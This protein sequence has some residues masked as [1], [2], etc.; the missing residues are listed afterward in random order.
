M[1][2]IS[3]Y[4]PSNNALIGKV[5]VTSQIE[6]EDVVFASRDAFRHWKKTPLATRV[7]ILRSAYDLF[8]ERKEEIARTVS[9][10]MG[11][12]IKLARDEV[13]Y[14][15]NYY[16]WY[17]DQAERYL[18]PET[19]FE[20]DTELHTVYYEPKGVIA[21]ITP[22]NYPFML[23][24]W[25]CIQPLLAGNTV[26]WKVSKEVIL[27]GKLIASIMEQAK[28]PPWVWQEVYG[29]GAVWDYLTDLDIDGITFTWS[30]SV[31]NHLAKKAHEKGIPVVM[32]L[33]WSAPGI[34]CEDA[35]I[36]S[37]LETIYFMRFSNSGQMCDGL[38]RLIV[39]A[40]RYN[41][42]IE[43]LSEKLASKKIG[44]ALDETVD[45]G[46]IVSERQKTILDEQYRDAIDKGAKILWKNDQFPI[47]G[48]GSYTQ[49][50]ILWNIQ[51][52]MRVWKEEVFWPILPVV[53][54]HALDEA[55]EL[56][57]DTIYG[58]WAYVFTQDLSTFHTLAQSIESGMVQLNNVNYCIPS[59]PFGGYKASGIGREH[60]KW[61][62]YEFVN[63]KVLSTPKIL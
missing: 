17:L 28:L 63:I 25:A 32:E 9:L 7:D 19:T 30:T 46:P 54:F 44:D 21:A 36:D 27:T 37:V 20:S 48:S 51:K 61:G 1:N 3:S 47:D 13:Q 34:I 43:K 62:F 58:L 52:D 6:I 59:D 55:I 18:S 16:I 60:G 2:E 38:K 33:G 24:A 10:E 42:L 29:D 31:G 23:F 53:P 15:L 35:D 26:I 22:W 12:P 45:I 8:V 57:N 50:S 39:H 56:A 49:A 11:M 4:N 40:S 14:G 41:E 5:R